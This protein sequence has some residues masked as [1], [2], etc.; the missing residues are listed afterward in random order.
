MTRRKNR[1]RLTRGLFCALIALLGVLIV[2]AQTIGTPYTMPTPRP[3][4]TP[5]CPG[6]L[7]ERLIVRERGRVVFGDERPLN[8]RAGPATSYDIIGQIEPGG[9]FVVVEGT[10]CSARYT[11]YR[12]A[13]GS[14]SGWIA[15]GD[16]DAYFVE[17][18]PPGR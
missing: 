8:V 16:G 7:R 9:V 18:Y 5:G 15:E 10:A 4:P 1:Y 6:S 2:S 11:W 14:L 12:V 13:R 17:P 3:S